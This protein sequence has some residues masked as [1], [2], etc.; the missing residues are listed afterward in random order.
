[1]VKFDSIGVIRLIV[2][3]I[4]GHMRTPKI[5]ALHRLMK[6]LNNR[7]D[8][9]E[10]FPLLPLDNS[11][12]LANTWLSGFIEADGSFYVYFYPN[13]KGTF[14]RPQPHFRL[15]QRA[16]Y[17]RDLEPDYDGSYKPIMEQI[18]SALGVGVMTS[19]RYRA[20]RTS[21]SYVVRS[22]SKAVNSRVVDYIH[23]FP[24]FSSKYLDF[25]AWEQIHP[26]V[27]EGTYR[28]KQGS[29][30]VNALTESMNTKR[31]EFSW[32]QW[33]RPNPTGLGW[34]GGGHS[35]ARRARLSSARRP[36]PGQFL[37]YR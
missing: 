34:T 18:G 17:H 25:V 2:S 35:D 8:Q 11:P 31:T 6:W 19:I 33:P 3:L 37:Y 30:L 20:T 14:L 5:E 24:L 26:I 29:E 7:P 1:V 10:N 15:E 36:Q 32:G 12:I 23:N 28:D 13:R 27:L 9:I 4:N 21:I 22:S 16:Q